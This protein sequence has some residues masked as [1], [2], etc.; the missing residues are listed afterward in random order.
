MKDSSDKQNEV[1]R[2]AEYDLEQIRKEFGKGMKLE[3]IADKLNM[4]REY[5]EF[6]FRFGIL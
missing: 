5:A 3:E 6:L 2:Q 1:F 4:D